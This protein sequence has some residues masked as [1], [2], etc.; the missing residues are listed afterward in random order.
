MTQKE[1]P[2]QG[3]RVVFSPTA[4]VVPPCLVTEHK[5]ASLGASA[6]VGTGL[7]LLVLCKVMNGTIQDIHLS[8]CPLLFPLP[9][10]YTQAEQF[11][12]LIQQPESFYSLGRKHHAGL[13]VLWL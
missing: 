8:Q 5:H 3:Q 10:N 11:Q 6:G 12:V 4:G 13:W 9:F 1:Q 7:H 2:G